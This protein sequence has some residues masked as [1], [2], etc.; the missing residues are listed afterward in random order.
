MGN[1][2]PHFI[3]WELTM[4]INIRVL[5]LCSMDWKSSLNVALNSLKIA[6]LYCVQEASCP[7]CNL[8]K[9]IKKLFAINKLQV[10]C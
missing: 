3:E 7:S 4:F 9:N 5:R 1:I 6:M 10:I 2:D 8:M